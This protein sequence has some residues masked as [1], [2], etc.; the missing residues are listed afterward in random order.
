MAF[1]NRVRALFGALDREGATARA[2]VLARDRD[3]N[4]DLDS[5]LV[6]ARTLASALDLERAHVPDQARD[7]VSDLVCDLANAL[8]SDYPVHRDLALN[9]AAVAAHE[10]AHALD[11]A[12]GAL[13]GDYAP[14]RAAGHEL[15]LSQDLASALASALASYHALVRAL[16]NYP[17]LARDRVLAVARYCDL[18]RGLA[19]YLDHLSVAPVDAEGVVETAVRLLPRAWQPRYREEY[20]AELAELSLGERDE[21]ARRVLAD[22]LEL[23]KE[24][25]E[26]EWPP[27]SARVKE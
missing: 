13:D 2:L 16:A 25:T 8:D 11:L 1:L 6:V 19:R 17:E 3:L 18:A 23:R 21:Y 9:R 7:L 14:D 20:R 15:D 26:T 12:L 27:D 5:A 24:L 22:V 4:F 10:L